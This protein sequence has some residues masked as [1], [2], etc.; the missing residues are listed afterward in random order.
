MNIKLLKRLLTFLC[1]L[2]L[3]LYLFGCS[4][5]PTLESQ[6]DLAF[7]EFSQGIFENEITSNTINLHYTLY[8][9]QSYG[10]SDYP[11]TLG[12]LN[13][14][15][16]EEDSNA[17]LGYF[18]TLQSFS[19]EN[20]SREN[21]ITYDILSLTFEN[22]LQV[23]HLPLYFELLSP[24]IGT[25]AQLPVLLAEYPFYSKDDVANYLTLLSQLDTYYKGI[26]QF[27][28]EKSDA[29]LFMSDTTAQRIIDQCKGFIENP[30]DNYLIQ[31][32]EDKL[33][34]VK[35]LTEE[36]IAF[37]KKSNQEA[38]YDHVIPAY[39]ILIQG[40]SSLKGTGQNSGG[41]SGHPDGKEYYQYL[42]KANTGI[43]DSI[44]DIQKRLDRQLLTD[45]A[46]LQ[47]LVQENPKLL[48]KVGVIDLPK[49]EPEDIL[50]SLKKKMKHDFPTP[51]DTSFQIK[52]VHP[53]MEKH[54]SPAFYLTPPID[55]IEDNVIYI[56]PANQYTNLELFTTLAHEG[57]PGHLYQTTYDSAQ[58]KHPLRSA[59]GFGGYSEG[60]A[61]YVEMYAYT[62]AEME[63][64]VAE[65]TRL[66]HSLLLCLYSNIDIGIHYSGWDRD[67]TLEY[68]SGFGF[69]NPE[70]A[71]SIYDAI[72]EEPT[73]Y[74]KY[75]LGYLKFADMQQQAKN[76]LG[77][78]FQLKDFHKFLLDLGP[79]PF[80]VVEKYLDEYI[81][82][83][84]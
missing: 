71:N 22:E 44:E 21:Q 65:I 23:K 4:S 31:I 30:Q 69:S 76:A 9:P 17:I 79:A 67:K 8:N 54:L 55:R 84:S 13:K 49:E 47:Q 60:W 80:P 81:K 14:G 83:Q 34:N 56:N 6:E 36:E 46:T 50:L 43:F 40:L 18:D 29:G 39:Q 35:G 12:S 5:Q 25:Q 41:L 74:L 1:L 32:F 2:S 72:V 16:I 33:E 82:S 28:Q 52:Y 53:S 48:E 68:L 62:L 38:L 66:N 26:I 75:Y 63:P 51:P 70:T 24:T 10:I 61:T 77:D 7:T 15:Q 11:V 27:Q 19:Y 45:F 37:Y 59:L 58:K 20:L 57:Y 64:Q 42:I 3:P 78:N 73:N